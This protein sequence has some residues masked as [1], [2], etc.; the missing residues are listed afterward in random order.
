MDRSPVNKSLSY[1]PFKDLKAKPARPAKR[2]ASEAPDPEADLEFFKNAMADVKEIREFRRMDSG[3]PG[4]APRRAVPEWQEALIELRKIVAGQAGITLSDTDEYIEWASPKAAADIAKRLHGG[5]FA[6][7][8]TLDLHGFTLADAE[9]AFADFFRDAL[10]R[11]LFCI[12]V[13]HGRGLRSP[14][15]PVLKEAVLGWLKGPYR[16][17]IWAYST[18]KGSDGGLGATYIILKKG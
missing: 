4:P 5:E 11:R 9:N 8:D 2:P 17:K 18:A 10:R 6:V 13:I 14:N 15:G 16:K 12:K 3:K 1:K 7:Q